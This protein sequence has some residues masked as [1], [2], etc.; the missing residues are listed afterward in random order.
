MKYKVNQARD[1]KNHKKSKVKTFLAVTVSLLLYAGLGISGFIYARNYHHQKI[2]NKSQAQVTPQVNNEETL[3]PT[4]SQTSAPTSNP[5][6]SSP[7]PSTSPS[8]NLKHDYQIPLPQNGL[9]PVLSRIP[10]KLPVVF[11]GIDDGI[12]KLSGNQALMGANH[13]QA[14]LFLVNRFIIGDP[15]YFADLQ[16]GTGSIIEDHT[17]DHKLLPTLSYDEQKQEICGQA[18]ALTHLYGQR[19][20]LMRPPGGA[21][22]SDTQRATAAC[23]IKAVI[24]WDVTVNNG[25][26]QYQ[27]GHSLRPGDIVL[28]HFRSTFQED[29]QAFIDE[30]NAAGLH[31]D[32]LENWTTN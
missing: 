3:T 1:R 2:A 17:L 26:L 12:T 7:L 23:N 21:Y 11:L 4:S 25:K 22:N 15:S 32:L 9:A 5:T 10:T 28:M 19:P 13:V 14:S 8:T 18:D 6:I 20:T 16:A 29:M 31:T 24:M 30:E 27:V